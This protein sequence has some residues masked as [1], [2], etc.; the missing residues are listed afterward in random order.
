MARRFL[1]LVG[2][3]VALAGTGVFVFVAV[4]VW[5]VKADVNR[6]A[7]YLVAKAHSAGDA[8]DRAIGFVREILA[9]AKSDL[10]IASVRPATGAA[11][12]VSPILHLTAAHASRELLGSVERAQGAVLAA[13][14]AVVVA[15]A[16]LDVASGDDYFPELDKLFGLS[17]EHLKQSRS[18]LVSI[19]GEL[20]S[21]RGILGTAPANLTVDQLSAVNA[22]LDQAN[23]LTN[24]LSDVVKMARARVNGAKAEVD[25]WAVWLS[26]AVTALAAVAAIGQLFMLR[27]CMRKLLHLPA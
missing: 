3:L 5:H 6:Q 7:R 16:A 14:D 1:S 2:V 22:A 13:A 15:D 23:D 27:F 10:A 26:Y 24:R 9:K 18:A 20:Q 4:K 19:S 17:P 8:T 12:A 11:G 21:A 25:L